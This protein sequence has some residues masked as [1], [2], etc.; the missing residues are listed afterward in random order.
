MVVGSNC[1]NVGA[2]SKSTALAY[3]EMGNPSTQ[4]AVVGCLRSR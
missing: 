2:A 3:S 4:T 1:T